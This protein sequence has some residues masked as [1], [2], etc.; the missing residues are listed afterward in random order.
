MA[1][2]AELSTDLAD[3]PVGKHLGERK[4]VVTPELV[5]RFAAGCRDWN[6]W[7]TDGSPFGS[8]VAPAL[9][10]SHEPWRFPGWYP[11]E[12]RGNLHVKQDWD[13]LNPIMVGDTYLCSAFVAERYPRRDR[14]VIVNEVMLRHPSGRPCARGRT[15]MAF[16]RQQPEGMV[17]DRQRERRADRRFEVDRASALEVLEGEVQVL[18]PE[19][20]RAAADGKDNYHSNPAIAREWGFP[21]VVVQ[22]VYNANIVSALLTRRFGAGWLCGGRMRMNFVNVTWGGD[23]VRAGIAVRRLID[24]EPGRRAEGDAWVEKED[25]TVT[26]IGSVSALV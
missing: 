8:P 13:L 17:V 26:A 16:L 1:W 25:G 5:A 22:G 15:H 4:V 19:L 3:I 9:I 2:G 18:T 12:V 23:R 20:C 6:S 24:E 10:G 7:Y 21:A 14:H 11:P